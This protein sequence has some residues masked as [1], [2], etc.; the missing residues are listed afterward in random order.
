MA[1]ICCSFVLAQ[2]CAAVCLLMRSLL[3]PLHTPGYSRQSHSMN[4]HGY[5]G[6]PNFFL[7]LLQEGCHSSAAAD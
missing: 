3:L 2:E 7:W 1:S 6:K 4:A 5:A